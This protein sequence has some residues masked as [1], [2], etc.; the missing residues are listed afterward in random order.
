MTRRKQK[1]LL[2]TQVATGRATRQWLV[3][4]HSLQPAS[5]SPACCPFFR[6]NGKLEQQKQ[7]QQQ[8]HTSRTQTS[9][10]CTPDEST[11]Q[12]PFESVPHC[13]SCSDITRNKNVNTRAILTYGIHRGRVLGDCIADK[14][15]RWS[16]YSRYSRDSPPQDRARPDRKENACC[17]LC[18]QCNATKQSMQARYQKGKLL[19][20]RQLGEQKAR[21]GLGQHCRQCSVNARLLEVVTR[22]QTQCKLNCPF[23]PSLPDASA[24]TKFCRHCVNN[25][26][27]TC[28]R[29]ADSTAATRTGPIVAL[30]LHLHS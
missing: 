25:N 30:P 1:L 26:S 21:I 20:L 2:H 23:Q 18:G 29:A 22:S 15:F 17:E 8:Q 27:D 19:L 13:S 3:I 9:H 11:P 6:S 5:V 28:I 24:T 10:T 7:E 4:L 14:A 12:I 16:P